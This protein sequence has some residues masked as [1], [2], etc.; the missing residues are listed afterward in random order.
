MSF[1]EYKDIENFY[2]PDS[3]AWKDILLSLG[4]VI[5]GFGL[6]EIATFVRNK[7][8]KD[9]VGKSF[10]NEIDALKPALV[11]QVSSNKTF[12]IEIAKYNFIAPTAFIYKNLD[13]V[14]SLDRLLV[15]EYCKKQYGEAHLKKVRIIYN[16]LTIIESEMER[17]VSFY[18]SYSAELSV[19]YDSYRSIANKYSRSV[20]DYFT[21][22]NL[23]TGDDKF[24]D[25]VMTLTK[26]TL[27]TDK[28]TENIVQFKDS[29]HRKLIDIEYGNNAH[30][31]YKTV[32]E[33]NQQGIDSLTTI[34]IKTKAFIRKVNTIT[35]SLGNCYQKIYDEAIPADINGSR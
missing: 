7:R 33:F 22:N 21:E 9:R 5:V 31:I 23:N 2:G 10:T 8:Q 1:I 24:V 11:N 17:L 3:E 28:E 14:K 29:L 32:S 15:S 34:I 20:A 35:T 26:E 18:E 6:S 30:P 16:Q 13:H 19:Q 27:F 25:Q 4:G 12:V